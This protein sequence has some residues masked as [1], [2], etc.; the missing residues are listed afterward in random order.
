M[1]HNKKI[2]T[3]TYDLLF[4]LRSHLHDDIMME[5]YPNEWDETLLYL[6][7]EVSI[8]FF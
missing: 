2:D 1:K 8:Q 3:Q 6:A 5:T 4:Q 7:D